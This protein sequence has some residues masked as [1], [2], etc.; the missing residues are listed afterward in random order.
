MKRIIINES[1][2]KRILEAYQP[3]FSFKELEKLYETKGSYAQYQYCK[4]M[5]G[6]VVNCGSSRLIFTLDDNTVLKLVGGEV[7]AGIDQNKT[8]YRLYEKC[9]SPLL[10][11]IYYHDK[12]YSFLVCESVLPA[13]TEDF[14]KILG[15]PW[16][17]YHSQNT[18]Q[19]LL[20]MDNPQKGDRE[21]G[22][23][24]YFDNIKEPYEKSENSL[25]DILLYI[26]DIYVME[27]G[28]IDP[29]MEEII[30]ET[31]WL[32]AMVE[33]VSEYGVEDF[34][35]IDNFGI[36]NRDGNPMIVLLDSGLDEAVYNTHYASD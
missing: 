4:E 2:K 24:K 19:Q 8:E 31:P 34:N 30:A 11:R 17:H 6:N 16:Y 28:E 35:R 1:Q 22:Y 33:L 7:E 3:K 29:Q 10:P 23:N 15:I 21:V 27:E 13:Q 18:E 14:E 26:E 12:H 32:Q 9:D 36:V 25:D 20:N 5:L